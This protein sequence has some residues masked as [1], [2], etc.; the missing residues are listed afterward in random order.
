VQTIPRDYEPPENEFEQFPDGSYKV[1]GITWFSQDEHNRPILVAQKDGRLVGRCHLILEDDEE[2]PPFSVSMGQMALLV[3]AF[4]G[5]ISKLP[6]T[7]EVSQAGKVS[8]F[9]EAVEKLAT[10]KVVEVE[11]SN[12]WANQIDGMVVPP[13][14]Y[15][16][17]LETIGPRNEDDEPEPIEG[18]YGP[19]FYLYSRIVAGEGGGPT[20]WKDAVVRDTLSYAIETDNNNNPQWQVTKNGAFTAAA[21][22]LA[23][24]MQFTAPDLFEEGYVHSNPYNLLPDW[25]T[26]AQKADLVY[27]G[28]RN[29]A[30]K[31][32]YVNM[33]WD[34]VEPAVEPDANLPFEPDTKSNDRQQHAEVKAREALIAFMNTL[35]GGEAFTNVGTLSLSAGGKA[36]AKQYF[37]PLR[38]KGVLTT[39][40]LSNLTFDDMVNVLTHIEIADAKLKEQVD[41][42]R[43]NLVA[44]GI[45]VDDGDF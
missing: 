21:T 28:Y 2:G 41:N 9:M 35:A 20:P 5:D 32:K 42:I 27:K 38:Q 12:G 10:G 18:K 26:E 7:P 40:T 16:Y 11:V 43:H 1:K 34:S 36:V 6:P 13:G 8:L 30:D 33:N 14:L 17:K 23:R 37:T 22:R 4:G 19:Y 24:L 3:K 31:S 25:L 29:K 44:A 15:Y 39:G 45:G